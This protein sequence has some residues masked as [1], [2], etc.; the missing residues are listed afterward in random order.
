VLEVQQSQQ[1][2]HGDGRAAQPGGEQRPPRGD[3]A[4]V[5]EVGVDAGELVGQASDF[6][7][8][9]RVPGG[10]RQ[11]GNAKHHSSLSTRKEPTAHSAALQPPS[12]SVSLLA[13]YVR[14][15]FFSGK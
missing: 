4:F 13:G 9:Q 1:G 10:W 2:L 12:G 7:W 6:G 5:V 3:E 14:P 8:E 11:S 15:E